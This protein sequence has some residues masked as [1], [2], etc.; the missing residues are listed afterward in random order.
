MTA[1]GDGGSPGSVLCPANEVL[2][3]LYIRGDSLVFRIDLL[4]QTVEAWKMSDRNVNLI[5]G[6]GTAHGTAYVLTC[7]IG[8]AIKEIDGDADQLVRSVNPSCRM[9]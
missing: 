1:G 4:C 8:T 2:I 5:S 9:L 6:I 7:P 3:G